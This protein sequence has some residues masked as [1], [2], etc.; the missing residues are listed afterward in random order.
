MITQVPEKHCF[1]FDCTCK[2][3]TYSYKYINFSDHS[4]L[5]NALDLNEQAQVN[6]DS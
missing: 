5:P 2:Y 6:E 3:Y 4:N 1:T